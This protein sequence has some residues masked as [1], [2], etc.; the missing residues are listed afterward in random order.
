[1]RYPCRKL[2]CCWKL[3][4]GK[5]LLLL[6]CSSQIL[7]TKAS[8]H[9]CLICMSSTARALCWWGG[10]GSTRYAYTLVC[11]Q[12]TELSQTTLPGTMLESYSD[13]FDDWTLKSAKSKLPLK[14]GH[15]HKVRAVPCASRPKVVITQMNTPKFTLMQMFFLVSPLQQKSEMKKW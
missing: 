7:I 11:Y 5:T 13:A 15:F 4:L 10:I 14:E 8:N 1:M 9:Y 12:I 6:E 2:S 3:T